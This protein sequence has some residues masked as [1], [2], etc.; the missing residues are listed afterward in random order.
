MPSFLKFEC[1]TEDLCNGVH[2]WSGDTFKVALTDTAPDIA[3]DKVLTDIAEIADGGGYSA[4]GY[5]LDNVLLT[6]AGGVSKI[7]IDEEEV[8][9]T[10][11]ALA[12]FRYLVIYNDT[13]AAPLNPLVGV[14]DYGTSEIYIEDSS[15]RLRF[16]AANGLMTTA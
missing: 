16:D 1:Y 12:Q 13:P 6:R 7:T 5:A 11:G 8:T 4:G 10:G 2:D 3:V 15:F 14:I 9:A